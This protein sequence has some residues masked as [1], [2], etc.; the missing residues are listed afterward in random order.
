MAWRSGEAGSDGEGAARVYARCKE[1]RK[2]QKEKEKKE[3]RKERKKNGRPGNYLAGGHTG[4][5]PRFR[6]AVLFLRARASACKSASRG[7]IERRTRA[8]RG[9]KGRGQKVRAAL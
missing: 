7:V 8:T 2:N 4:D 1:R 6:V 5:S 3:G 9:G